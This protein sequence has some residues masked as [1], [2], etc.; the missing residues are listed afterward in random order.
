[1]FILLRLWINEKQLSNQPWI[2]WLL[3][4]QYRLCLSSSNSTLLRIKPYLYPLSPGGERLVVS[5][6][7][8]G[9]WGDWDLKL[10]TRYRA[11]LSVRGSNF[12]PLSVLKYPSCFSQFP[13]CS[14]KNAFPSS[15]SFSFILLLLS[16]PF[17]PFLPTMTPL[18]SV[19]LAAVFS[20]E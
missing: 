2:P 7:I 11:A 17:C 12:G 19:W 6:G 13:L 5:W 9:K 16:H 1:M 4:K 15:F 3:S 18:S 20:F 14:E 10:A 8:T